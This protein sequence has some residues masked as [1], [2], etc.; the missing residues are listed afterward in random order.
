MLMPSP[1]FNPETIAEP[2]LTKY[3]RKL[4][5]K[6][7]TRDRRYFTKVGAL[8]IAAG[9]LS[10]YWGDVQ[11]NKTEQ[12]S[13]YI[14]IDVAY[15]PEEN[16]D[17]AMIFLNGFGTI[18][19]DP[20]EKYQ[21]PSTQLLED[22]ERWTVNYGDAVLNPQSIVNRLL[23]MAEERG[24]E[25]F[26]IYGRSIGGKI[27]AEVLLGL[28]EAGGPFVDKII[29]NLT[30]DGIETLQ[31]EK[32][33]Q[34]GALDIVT[35][36]PGAQYSSY[37]REIGEI[38]ARHDYYDH[39]TLQERI[40]RFF[41]VQE[42]VQQGLANKQLPAMAL[43]VDQASVVTNINL[44]SII[45]K[46]G[47]ASEAG[48]RPLLI[49]IANSDIST[50]PIVNTDKASENICEYADE[51][52]LECYIFYVKNDIHTRP[53]I[54]ADEYMDTMQLAAPIINEAIEDERLLY[55]ATQ[56]FGKKLDE[57]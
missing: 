47:E 25:T 17:S 43:L 20:I 8:A 41:K 11:E 51:S 28:I 45:N 6:I 42:D 12:A 21:G 23:D 35:A 4:M 37:I 57:E 33:E 34:F 2:V 22:S 44:E 54:V 16:T 24:I 52:E 7:E 36:I 19:A 13:A 32:R 3:E 30:P 40:D 29:F 31:P 56:A 5:R 39:G 10:G 49:Y 9:L 18:D 46:I 38:I 14:D 15:E 26:S 48:R 55:E 53:D 27:G 1:R 50:D